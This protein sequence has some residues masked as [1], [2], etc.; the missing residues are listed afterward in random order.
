MMDDFTRELE[1]CAKFKQRSF[2]TVVENHIP[3]LQ[4]HTEKPQI[5]L[6]GDSM[7]ERMITT[8]DSHSF[9]PWPS[10]TML[11]DTPTETGPGASGGSAPFTR[12]DHVFNAGVGGD[13]YEHILYRLVGDNTEGRQLPGLL[14]T[15]KGC[16]IALW[17]VHA[18][19]NNLHPKRGLTDA[20]VEKLRLVLQAVLRISPPGARLLLTGLFRRTDI[21]DPLVE[22]ANRKLEGLVV[23]MNEPAAPRISFVAAPQTVLEE[24]LDDHVHLNAEGYRLWMR[25]LYPEILGALRAR[26]ESEGR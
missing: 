25:Y 23:S 16:D 2:T 12:L 10:S 24:H 5:V 21:A 19:T 11:P 4:N 20:D 9:Q 13:R 22:E 8:G 14:A 3:L 18:G 6:L 17:V 26:E 7:I 1:A 15:L